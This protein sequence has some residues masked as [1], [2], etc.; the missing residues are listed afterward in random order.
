MKLPDFE[1]PRDPEASSKKRWA[2]VPEPVRKDVEQRVSAHLPADILT[3][4]R[5]LHVRSSYQ[6]QRRLLSFRR[7]H[8]CPEPVP[9]TAQ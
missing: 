4:L 5:D 6:S 1:K 9:R 2:E 8:G 3:K 7:R